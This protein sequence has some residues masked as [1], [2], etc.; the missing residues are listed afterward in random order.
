MPLEI[1]S[2]FVNIACPNMTSHLCVVL[3]HPSYNP[4]KVVFVRISTWRDE[5]IELNDSSCIVNVG[6]HPFIRHKSYVY[7]R[8]AMCRPLSIL[9]QGIEKSVLQPHKNCTDDFLERILDGAANSKF[10]PNEIL[11]I[12][13]EQ[14]LIC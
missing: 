5:A 2:T 8:E 14:E 7:Y 1:G 6:D 13:Q 9:Q 10:T 12:L 3:S 4:N 11:E